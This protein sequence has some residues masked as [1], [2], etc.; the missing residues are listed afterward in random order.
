ML[1]TGV[2]LAGGLVPSSAS[3]CG[4]F[5]CS[6]AAGVNQAAERIVF[7]N[8]GDGTV[9]AVIEI[10]YQGP[11]D[12]FSWLLPISSVPEGDQIAVG[13]TLAFQRLQ[14]ATNP[15]YQ[16]T[17]RVEGVCD[18]QMYAN[19]TGGTSSSFP[20][21]F[22]GGGASAGPNDGVTVEAAGVVG[23]FEWTVI[24]L[25]PSLAEPADAAVTWLNKNGYDVPAGAPGMLGPYLADGMKL[26]ALRLQKG[27]T[28]GSIRPIVLTYEADKPMIPIK[29]TAVA[30][31]DD[32]GVMTWILG[33]GRAVPVNY[34][35]LELNEAR[36]NWFN[37]NA[38]YNDVVTAAANEAEGQGFVTEYAQPTTSLRNVVWTASDK[39]NWDAFKLN[40]A[41]N[42]VA[43]ATLRQAMIGFSQWDGFWEV[44]R[45]HVT[46]PP[47]VTLQELQACP[48]CHVADCVIDAD[49]STALES[50]VIKPAQVLQDLLDAHAKVTRLYSTLS[51][52]EMT[53]D[54]LFT[55]NPTLPNVSNVH[56]AERVIECQAGYYQ[57]EAP[58]RIELPQGGVVRGG[59]AQVGAWPASFAAQ[60]ANRRILR[61]G[62][63]GT[64]QVL[65]D[66]SGEI[67]DDVTTYS[68]SVKVPAPSPFPRD[69]M[70]GASSTAGSN[71]AGEPATNGNAVNGGNTG[72]HSR[73]GPSG[74]CSLG[75]DGASGWLP[76]L[77]VALGLVTRRRK[78]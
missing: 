77:A 5:F 11:S 8:N 60:P 51:A 6:Q 64:G 74:G 75:G 25:D 15:Q 73:V 23:S 49:F 9:T 63:T 47:N 27:A 29:L 26:L 2:A 54:P 46:L 3:A 18:P 45:K 70:G 61:A 33:E 48:D 40:D 62:A 22:S 44:V 42:A 71:S 12:K 28:T 10:Q 67:D 14:Q 78:R 7:A 35:A 31:N 52:D 43:G 4:G 24:S 30:A 19:G 1:A 21:S 13:S 56:N 66:N 41:S 37:A 69:G 16:L 20:G 59:P 53:V 65:E 32:M 17:T 57:F 76:A 50:D 38:N 34:Y 55:L 72:T 68:A 36:I 58:W 39:A